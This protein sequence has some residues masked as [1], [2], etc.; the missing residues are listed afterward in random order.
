MWQ[1]KNMADFEEKHRTGT[2]SQLL[3]HNWEVHEL[4][5]SAILCSDQYTGNPVSCKGPWEVVGDNFSSLVRS[6]YMGDLERVPGSWL[7]PES[8]G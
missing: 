1:Q 6:T 3:I 7:Q 5:N 2:V 4:H 8:G